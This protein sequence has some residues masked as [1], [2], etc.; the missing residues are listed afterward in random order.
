MPQ[1]NTAEQMPG[2]GCKIMIMIVMIITRITVT[3]FKSRDS[4]FI[5][6]EDALA[7]QKQS[8]AVDRMFHASGGEPHR[9][10]CPELPGI[11]CT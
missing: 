8:S 9:Q 7:P 11:T 4:V 1:H 10:I 2:R 3:R 6:G 5:S